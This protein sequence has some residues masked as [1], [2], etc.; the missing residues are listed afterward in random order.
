[1]SLV[2]MKAILDLAKQ[3]NY[4][5]PAFDAIDYVSA[6]AIIAAAEKLSSSVIIMV[7]EAALP[8]LDV[9]KFF[10]FVVHRAKSATVPI[11]VQLDHGQKFETIIKAIHHGFS[12]VMIDGSSLPFEDNVALTKKVVEVAHAV[13][14]SVE[15]E[16]GHVGGAE[17]DLEG[18][19]IVDK[20]LYTKPEDAKK[21]VDETNVDA[22]A[23]AFGTV[24]GL[25]KSEPKLDLELLQQI[26]NTVDVPLVMHGGSGVSDEEFKKSV[27]AGINKINIFTEISM[28]AVQQ[29]VA[30]AQKKENKLHFGELAYVAKQTVQSLAE[31]YIL[32][33]K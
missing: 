16:I 31:R 14:V 33:F 13:G 9:D 21:F 1:M 5:V 8:M 10:D 28:A 26:R 2:P 32:L 22:L 11:A 19:S 17:G 6:E 20:D 7:P 23:I 29:S 15:A 25:Y 4:A 18:G 3:E 27:K 30:Y 24:H 12:G